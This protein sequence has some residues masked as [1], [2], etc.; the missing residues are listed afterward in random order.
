MNT[1]FSK[2]R[3]RFRR[4]GWKRLILGFL[5]WRLCAVLGV[6]NLFMLTWASI[7]AAYALF[8]QRKTN[9]LNLNGRN[10]PTTRF[11]DELAY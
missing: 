9:F 5:V 10:D 8:T 4:F 3:N 6:S 2:L 11:M 7:F 1:I